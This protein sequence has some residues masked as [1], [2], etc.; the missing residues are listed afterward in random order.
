MYPATTK[1]PYTIKAILERKPEIK[2]L[3]WL[4][5]TIHV[6]EHLDAFSLEDAELKFRKLVLKKFPQYYI[7]E[8]SEIFAHHIFKSSTFIKMVWRMPRL[9]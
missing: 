1:R 8:I 7:K 5:N 2:A 4:D 9:F 6:E 3:F